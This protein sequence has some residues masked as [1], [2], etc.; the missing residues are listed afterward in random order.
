MIFLRQCK[1]CNQTYYKSAVGFD[2][3]CPS[4]GSDEYTI[5]E[6]ESE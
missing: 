5:V 4:C 6:D 2:G 1:N 3:T